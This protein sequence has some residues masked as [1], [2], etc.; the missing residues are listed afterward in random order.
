M[1]TRPQDDP[2][3][4]YPGYARPHLAVAWVS[5]DRVFAEFGRDLAAARRAYGRFVQAGVD[6]PPPSPFAKAVGHLIL[7]SEAF[8]TRVRRLL[9]DRPD[10]AALPQLRQLRPRP[11]LR[12]IVRGGRGPLRPLPAGL[13]VRPAR[14]RRQPRVSGLPG[15][16]T[17]RLLS[18]PSRRS[19][20][21]P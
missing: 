9:H 3:S 12:R 11:A 2:W 21:L 8:V 19:P 7:G 16:P 6:N 5:Y 4:S 13:A 20:G 10:D 17:S 15:S 1:V 18:E 14:R